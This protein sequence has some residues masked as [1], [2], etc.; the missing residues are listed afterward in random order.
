MP[1]ILRGGAWTARRIRHNNLRQHCHVLATTFRG[2]DLAALK[3]VSARVLLVLETRSRVLTDLHPT[4]LN[5]VPAVVRLAAYA[6]CWLRSPED[7]QP[8]AGADARAQW[9]DLLRHLLARYPVPQFLDAAWQMWGP[10]VHF[11]RDCWCALAQGRSL[12]EVAGFPRSVSSRLLHAALTRGQG[13]NLVEAI[14]LAQL[15]GLRASPSLEKAVLASRVLMEFSDHARWQRLAAKFA[16]G[17]NALA[18]HFSLVADTLIAVQNHRGAGQVEKLLRLPLKVLISHSIRFATRL[19]QANGHLLTEAQVRTAAEKAELKK[20]ASAC[21]QP[22]LGDHPYDSR[23]GNVRGHATW[24]IEELHSVDALREEGRAMSHCVHRYAHRCRT[25]SSA[26]FSVRHYPV[27]DLSHSAGV[28]CATVEVHPRT[29]KVVQI[30]AAGNR[31]V[32]NT[33]MTI[34]R[35]WSAAHG[36]AC[37]Q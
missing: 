21:W 37:T 16:A 20:L 31:A 19:L 32:N 7:W 6:H 3:A 28:S 9:A 2:P 26:I 13:R 24:R 10:L 27:H 34:I 23:I 36:L 4:E 30:R 14:W 11:E 18:V 35:E 15:S 12:R 33:I 1:V 8:N 5:A 29:W 17:N 22:L 25:G